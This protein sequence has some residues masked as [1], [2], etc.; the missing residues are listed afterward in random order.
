MNPCPEC[1]DY[2][3][4]P[5]CVTCWDNGKQSADKLAME[6]DQESSAEAGRESAEFD[7]QKPE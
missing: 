3:P 7:D 2:E 6:D 5:F 1:R 4:N